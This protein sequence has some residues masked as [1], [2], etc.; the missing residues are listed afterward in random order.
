M[1]P[2][3]LFAAEASLQIGTGHVMRCL[4]L[5]ESLQNSGWDCSFVSSQTSYDLVSRLAP[6]P[7]IDPKEFW[8]NPFSAKL[9]V[10]DNYNLD[11]SYEN[12]FRKYVE[13]ILVIDDLADRPHNCDILL[14]QNLGSQISDY[15]NLVNENCKILVGTKFALLRPEFAKLRP[16]ALQKRSKTKK[17]SKILIN[18]GGSDINNH[19][20]KALENLETSSFQGEV[21]VVLGFSATH[22]DSVKN[23]AKKSK[24]KITVHRAA[25]MS[26]LIFEN[27]LA[28]A[29]GGS[30]AW[31]RCCLGL[32][33][34][35][36]KIADNQEQIF[37][38]LGSK[39][40][41]EEYWKDVSAN[42]QKYCDDVAKFADGDGA[43]RV[44]EVI[45]RIV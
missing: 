4:V 31:E 36:I 37:N 19:S 12:H 38:E 15:Q 32:P 14:D 41:F 22:F 13:T 43:K 11:S 16:A 35:I 17:V 34:Y 23:F 26:Q 10:V 20:L 30:S 40:S 2:L 24:N 45:E 27:D 29:A 42:Y 28:L 5:A 8:K 21:D 6:F 25:D 1:K 39:K 3:A 44:F 18:F 33:T 9:L 7:R